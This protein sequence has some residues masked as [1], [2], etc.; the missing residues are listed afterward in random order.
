MTTFVQWVHLMGAV[1]GVGGLGYLLFILMPALGGLN[2]DARAALST[3]VARRFR[4]VSWSAIVALLL[5]GIY[6][7]RE[8]Y[9]E[10]AWGRSWALLTVKI[11][12]ALVLFGIV[13]TLTLPL[14]IFDPIRNR[15]TGWLIAAFALGLAVILISAYLRRG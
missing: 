13:L 15:R 8:Y 10:V 3:T 9:W 2:Q 4:W 7:V 6:N 12:L 1:L 11:I 5:S 14:K